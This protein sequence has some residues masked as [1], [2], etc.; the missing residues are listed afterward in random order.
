MGNTV[1]VTLFFFTASSAALDAIVAR[2]NDDAPGR[3][4]DKRLV[5]VTYTPTNVGFVQRPGGSPM[6]ITVEL[7]CV[8][9]EFFFLSALMRWVFSAPVSACTGN[10]I[11]D[12]VPL[13]TF[14]STLPSEDLTTN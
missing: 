5:T 8:R 9:H 6:N 3:T 1:K 13:P 2:M 4:I 12:G 10:G 14:T 7:R 11:T